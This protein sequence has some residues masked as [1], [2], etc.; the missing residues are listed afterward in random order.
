MAIVGR[1]FTEAAALDRAA[2]EPCPNCRH[3]RGEHR[4]LRRETWE[5]RGGQLLV[6]PNPE[7]RAFHF[8]CTHDGCS[9]VLDRT[10]SQ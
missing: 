9:C 7:Y 3:G 1:A 5:L 8:H 2:R 4:E 6:V 10:E